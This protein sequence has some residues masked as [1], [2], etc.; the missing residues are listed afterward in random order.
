MGE[1]ELDGWRWSSLL[2]EWWDTAKFVPCAG[3]LPRKAPR[4]RLL[5]NRIFALEGLRSYSGQT[6]AA[7]ASAVDLV[8]VEVAPGLAVS[9]SVRFVR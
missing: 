6:V 7:S 2:V 5:D 3:H 4:A 8:P 1:E 9:H